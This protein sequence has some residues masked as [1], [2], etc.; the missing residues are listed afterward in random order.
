MF[1][2]MSEFKSQ[3]EY[4]VLFVDSNWNIKRGY[5]YRRGGILQCLVDA[6]VY[7]EGSIILVSPYTV[8]PLK[9]FLFRTFNVQV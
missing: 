8:N 6:E 1:I 2:S 9:L 3:L 7:T 4:D 5:L